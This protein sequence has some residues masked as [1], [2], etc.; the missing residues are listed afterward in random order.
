M[1]AADGELD[2]EEQGMLIMILG[3]NKFAGKGTQSKELFESSLK[4]LKKK[5]LRC[6]FD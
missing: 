1:M 6:I 5:Y 3:R 2:I 4:Y